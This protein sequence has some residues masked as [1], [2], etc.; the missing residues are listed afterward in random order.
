MKKLLFMGALVAFGV[1]GCASTVTEENAGTTAQK[2]Y[3]QD[4]KDAMPHKEKVAVF[5]EGKAEDQQMICRKE[6]VTGSH[7]KR[8]V[9][10]TVAQRKSDSESAREALGRKQSGPTGGGN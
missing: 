4:E 5:N 9:C 2:M 8:R 10:R 7:R 3:T 1:A 6:G